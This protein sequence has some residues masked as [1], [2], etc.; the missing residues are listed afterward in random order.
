MTKLANLGGKNISPKQLTKKVDVPFVV[1]FRD[2]LQ[3]GYTFKELEKTNNKEFQNFLDKVSKMTVN[4][5]DKIYRRPTDKQD[6][7]GEY[8]VFH[9]EVSDSFRMHVINR[10]GHYEVIRLDP[11]H[12]VH[13]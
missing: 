2:K 9:Y 8:Q 4:Q 10:N 11:N 5:V 6:K 7:Y 3:S 13:K 12:K 1:C